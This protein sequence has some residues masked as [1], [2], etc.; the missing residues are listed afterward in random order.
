MS[1]AT[2][3]Q[4][5]RIWLQAALLFAFCA[6]IASALAEHPETLKQLAIAKN[7]TNYSGLTAFSW[8]S[9]RVDVFAVG[10][11]KSLQ[12]KF[13]DGAWHDWESLGG[14]L[15]SPPSVLSI[16]KE[17]LIVFA[18]GKDNAIWHIFYNKGKWS[19]W[20]SLGGNF[21]SG[22][23]VISKGPNFIEVIAEG[24]DN[25]LR[26]IR[27]TGTW[28]DWEVIKVHPERTRYAS[29]QWQTKDGLPH[30]FVYAICQTRDGYLWL[31]TQGGLARFDGVH[32]THLNLEDAP[33]L[34]ERA[35]RFIHQ[36]HDGV[37]WIGGNQSLACWKDGKF[38][39]SPITVRSQIKAVLETT[40]GSLWIGTLNGLLRY[41]GG[42]TTS[43]RDADGLL[44]NSILS[45][46]ENRSGALWIGTSLGLISY[47]KGKFI[48]HRNA[49]L[50]DST[51]QALFCDKENNLWVGLRGGGVFKSEQG[52]ARV[53]RKQEGIPDGFINSIFED[54]RGAIWVG[55]MGGLCQ[56]SDG[57][58]VSEFNSDGASYETV[59]C[60]AEDREGGLW[61]GTK[62]GVTQLQL[63]PFES[64]TKQDGLSHNNVTSVREDRQG[65]I[66][67]TTWGGGANKVSHDQILS[68]NRA[69]SA[70]YD[71]LLATEETRDGSLWFGADHDGGLF[72]FK[73]NVLTRFGREHGIT[74]PAIRVI[75]E[76]QQTNLWI[77]TSGALYRR[78]GEGMFQRFTQ[79]NGLSGNIVRAIYQDHSGNIWIGT[80]GGLSVIASNE[81]QRANS[82]NP[83]LKTNFKIDSYTIRDGLSDNR[84]V[85]IH[86]DNDRNLWIGTDGGGLNRFPISNLSSPIHTAV[87]TTKQG[88]FSDTIFEILE[89]DRGNFWMSGLAGVFRVRKGD[90]DKV[91]SGTLSNVTC[92]AYGKEEGLS[93]VLCSGVSKPAGWKSRDGRL[94]FPTMRGVVVVDPQSIKENDSL[95]PVIIEKVIADGREFEVSQTQTLNLPPGKGELEFHYT[96]L[97]LRNPERNRFK[98]KLEGIDSDWVTAETRRIAHYTHL[99]PGQYQFRVIGC[100]SDGLWNPTE[101]VFAFVLAPHFWQTRWFL[102]LAILG[103]AGAVAGLVRYLIWRR[104]KV[105]LLVLEQQHAVERERIRIAQ[106]MHDELGARLTEIQML[107]DRG[108]DASQAS[109]SC[110]SIS[111][112]ARDTTRSLDAIVWAVNPRNDSLAKMSAYISNYVVKFLARSSISCRLDLQNPWPDLVVSSEMRHNIFLTVKEA[113]NNI[114]KHSRASQVS[115]YAR[116][117]NDALKI[118][119][120]DDGRGFSTRAVSD[121]GNGLQNMQKRISSLKGEF[122]LCS[123]PGKGTTVSMRIPLRTDSKEKNA[124]S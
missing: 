37:V 51:V 109:K 42:K 122:N 84:I 88:L 28:Q 86:E 61:L 25:V 30:N 85:A 120:Q 118:T 90:F 73:D 67:V 58:F 110:A 6:I 107:S 24:M 76:D 26:R 71:L 1:P 35:I 11:D 18:R 10:P 75:Y 103:A 108:Q 124:V 91:D 64:R 7:W 45:L 119:I 16:R 70:F 66:W 114:T 21:G 29:R 4:P 65:N 17:H 77:G 3:R 95:P 98:Y 80:E 123:E 72:Q 13:Y 52:G 99:P 34:K 9:N 93:S 12:H 106:D 100:N 32:F 57:R 27:W 115:F 2:R 101:D 36:T 8:G 116:L 56:Q 59:Y 47:E 89:D 68:F 15:T 55:T 87:F 53:F 23:R 83:N 14:V 79:T 121:F 48:T 39:P 54:S 69:N 63:K 41:Q 96:A 49:G 43:Y 117:E 81:L 112:A 74:D 105:R 40:D 5:G 104:V 111:E 50:V 33:Q 22:P 97:S 92:F 102:G 60:T 38:F 62:E 113:V 78:T 46:C 31:G 20:L 19:E 44:S 94:W 82:A